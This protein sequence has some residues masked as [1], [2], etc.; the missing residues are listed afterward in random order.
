MEGA[1]QKGLFRFLKPLKFI[2]LS[3]LKIVLFREQFLNLRYFPENIS[4]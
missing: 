1:T 3:S 2:R 4:D